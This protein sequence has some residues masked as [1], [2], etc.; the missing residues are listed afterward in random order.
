MLKKLKIKFILATE[1]SLLIV[2]TI[3]VGAI[4]IFNY[5]SVISD[6]DD[7]LQLIMDNKGRFPNKPGM[8][9]PGLDITITPESPFE[10]RYFTV[11]IENGKLKSVN[12]ASIAAV[13]DDEAVSMAMTVLSRK[14]PKGFLGNYRFLISTK[15][16]I[17]G[18]TFLDC[19][20]SL[21]SAN[22]FLLLSLSISILV[23]F[24]VFMLV[25]II[26]DH[27]VK[28]II[29]G[30]EKQK[31]FITDAGHDI[32]TPITIIDADAELIEMEFGES[33]WLSDIK[34][35]TARMTTLTNELI[36]LSRTEER[37]QTPHIDF[38]LS[39]VAEEVVNSFGAPAKTKNIKINLSVAPALFYHG[40]EDSVRKLFTL[41]LDNAVKYSPAEK[42]IDLTVRKQGRGVSIKISN[43]APDLT[44]KTVA[45][46]FD[47]FYRSD[48]AR[49]SGGG[50]GIGLSVASAIV[51]SH[52]GKINAHKEGNILVI[53]AILL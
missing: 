52:K 53:E 7:T 46:M 38:P 2:I 40:D 10:S 51:S 45:R 14:V 19:T 6:A 21:D 44:D 49:S 27:I 26:S 13:D 41:L 43:E 3:I 42:S 17:T 35:Q 34:K 39:E 9:K 29:Q 15:G 25:W 37:Q 36:Y 5:R 18:I 24:A 33:E 50:F 11:A 16:E 12:T 28:P 47:R 1:L 23:L 20:R 22:T 8:I 31:R 30:Y 48:P 32:K 4:N